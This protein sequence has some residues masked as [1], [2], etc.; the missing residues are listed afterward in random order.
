MTPE[1]QAVYDL[2]EKIECVGAGPGYR[3]MALAALRGEVKRVGRG[4][5]RWRWRVWGVLGPE[6][7]RD[8]FSQKLVDAVGNAMIVMA[9][10]ELA[11]GSG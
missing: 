11:R 6:N 8:G 7:I 3:Y 2:V 5:F 9:Q 10:T 4:R 1:Q